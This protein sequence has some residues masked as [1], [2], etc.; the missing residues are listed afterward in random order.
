MLLEYESFVYLISLRCKE[1]PERFLDNDILIWN[2]IVFC[3]WV[4]AHLFLYHSFEYFK[5][6]ITSIELLSSFLS[7]FKS[8]I[9]VC[10]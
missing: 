8:Y 9:Y 1:F 6:F 3:E 5:D 7:T 2:R 10:E 4:N